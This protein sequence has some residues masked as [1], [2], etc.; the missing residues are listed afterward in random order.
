MTG[1]SNTKRYEKHRHDSEQ[2]S[3]CEDM[4][5]FYAEI[6]I[7]LMKKKAE[8]CTS[9]VDLRKIFVKVNHIVL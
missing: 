8:L 1:A 7:G 3:S 4:F 5:T 6:R 2:M 9:F